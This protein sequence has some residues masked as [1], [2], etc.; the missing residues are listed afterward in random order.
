M[1]TIHYSARYRKRLL[2]LVVILSL[3]AVLAVS[4]PALAAPVVTLTPSAGVPG[5]QVTITGTVFDSYKGDTIHIFFDNDEISS[6]PMEV[7]QTGEFTV[8][9]TIPADTSPGRHWIRVKSEAGSTSFLA[10][11]FFIIE[12]AYISLNTIDGP[13]GTQVTISGRGFYAGR[14]VELLYYN[15]VGD[16]IA[17]VTASSDGKFNYNYVIPASTGGVHR[18]TASNTEGNYAEAEFE[19]VPELTL[20]LASAGPLELL[21]ARGTGFGYRTKVD[22]TINAITAATAKTGDYG[23]FEI[24]FNVPDIPPATY[25]IKARDGAGNIDIAKFTVTAGVHLSETTEAIGSQ[26]TVKGTGFTPN[27]TVN[28]KYDDQVVAT[29]S[30]DN[31]GSF[32]AAFDVPPSGG[33]NHTVTVTD[34]TTTKQLLFAVETDSPAVPSLVQPSNNTDTRASAHFD[35]YEVT[36]P[37]M[38]VVYDLQIATDEAFLILVISK[39][40]LTESEYYLESDEILFSIAESAT[41][42]WR[43]RAI[44][45]ASNKGQ[46][47]EA[48]TFYVNPPQTPVLLTPISDSKLDMP[49]QFNW[50]AVTSLSMPVVYTLQIATGLEFKDVILE[51][52][53][54]DSSDLTL[55][56]DDGPELERDVAY[57]WRV[58]ATDNDNNES[59]WS[60]TGSFYISPS[61]HFPGW[62]IYTLIG[63]VVIIVVFV[64]FRVGRR[65]AYKPPE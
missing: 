45:G 27:G 57:Y 23:Y 18:I 11:T 63:I 37:S 40:G 52:T 28:I 26:L 5:T 62:A 9:F 58:K 12:D 54:I 21:T 61:F 17:S 29:A 64:A 48:W 38:P 42:Y 32:T 2:S 25:D 51:E 7:P 4:S 46:W 10:E 34:G 8:P 31:N 44:D 19:V 20:N 1:K 56:K 43:V 49:V 22:I 16:P 30:T 33:G 24:V 15:V 39:Q 55:N 13:V 35:W 6:S 36:D 50:Q 41:Y 59:A 3:L 53:M 47:S 65:T 14:T 60:E